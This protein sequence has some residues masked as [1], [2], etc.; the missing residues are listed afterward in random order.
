MNGPV[1]D[2]AGQEGAVLM[3]ALVMAG[4]LAALSISLLMV[5]DTERRAAANASGS[6]VA[7]AAAD[8]AIE[9]A[10]VD[11]R[12]TASW[13]PLVN[14]SQSSGFTDR[15]RRVAL[16]FG[17]QLDLD[18]ATADLQADATSA[19][20]FGSDTPRW[21]LFSWGPLAR[22]GAPGA[23]D[24]LQYVAVWIADDPGDADGDP[25]ADA[26]GQVTLHAEAR[27]PGGARRVVEA[28]VAQANP[29]AVRLISWR[30]VR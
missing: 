12:R 1:N 17:G 11:L 24:S 8:A 14:G 15:A 23:V 27:G 30:E 3:L 28:S 26:N 21:Q 2:G 22:M 18:A 29:G 13:T 19:A 20:T 10:L 5:A 9:R 25:L 7:L 4:L 6:L 16:P